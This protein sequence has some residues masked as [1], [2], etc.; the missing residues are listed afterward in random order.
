MPPLGRYRFNSPTLALL[1]EAG[2]HVARTVPAGAVVEV[3]GAF[4]RDKLVEVQWD[5]KRVMIFA[6]DL[7]NRA[8][9]IEQ[10]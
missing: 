6:Q 2:R 7:R 8:E 10:R 4:E 5:G 1:E 3:G 9:L